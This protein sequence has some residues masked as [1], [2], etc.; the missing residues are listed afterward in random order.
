MKQRQERMAEIVRKVVGEQLRRATPSDLLTI[1]AV[2]VS[3][4]LK[5]AT[6]WISSLGSAT[7]DQQLNELL[8]SHKAQLQKA[9][10]D[11]ITTKFTPRLSFRFDVAA[12]EANRI[13]HLIDKANK[14]LD[15]N[16]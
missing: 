5:Y 7:N 1:T 14:G 2:E 15:H 6:V 12:D 8:E 10:A 13:Q 16:P 4:D 9:L 3:P 11:Y